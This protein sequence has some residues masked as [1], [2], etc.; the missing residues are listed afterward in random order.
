MINENHTYLG[1][2]VLDPVSLINHKVLEVHFPDRPSL[3][4]NHLIASDHDVEVY[5]LQLG[6]NKL[7]L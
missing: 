5:W 4:Q 1:L 7:L 6:L 2:L 3:L